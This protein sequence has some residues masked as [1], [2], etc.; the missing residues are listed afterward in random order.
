ML[1][2]KRCNA[3][4]TVIWINGDSAVEFFSLIFISSKKIDDVFD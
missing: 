2:T 1:D 3:I 4:K